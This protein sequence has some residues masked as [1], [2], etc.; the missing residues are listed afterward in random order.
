MVSYF[1]HVLPLVRVVQSCRKR[2]ASGTCDLSGVLW[3]FSF[4]GSGV[5]E[6]L[7]LGKANAN[8][9]S[10]VYSLLSQV[11]YPKCVHFASL[12]LSQLSTRGSDSTCS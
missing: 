6:W 1:L 8:R 11:L 10:R 4:S 5:A 9:G 2:S 12:T 3:L 7:L